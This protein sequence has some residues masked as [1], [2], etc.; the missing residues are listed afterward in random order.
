[1]VLVVELDGKIL[2]I[3]RTVPGV[4]RE[5]AIGA[6][7]Y[8]YM[9]AEHHERIRAYLAEVVE[10]RG[11]LSYQV[12]S[13]GPYGSVLL[14][15]TH[16]GPIER[17]GEVVALSFVSWEVTEEAL[18]VEDRYRVLA[19]AGIEGLIVH[20]NSVIVDAN[21]A[22]CEMF[23][24]SATDLVGQP[25]TKLFAPQSRELV[26]REAFYETGTF[27]QA[28]GQRRDGTSLAIEASGKS[29]PHPRGLSTVIA[30]RDAGARTPPRVRRIT[31]RAR[32]KGAAPKS[33]APIELSGR[34]LEVLELLAQGLT[35]REVSERIHVSART[36]DHHVS[37][38]LGKLGAPNRTAAAMAARRK[39]LLRQDKD[40]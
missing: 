32:R 2:F 34:E 37:H 33:A 18:E 38:I 24:Y 30:V 3:D 16:V 5:D 13:I 20:E 39:G 36:V 40:K 28:T 4:S 35:N 11:S 19:D 21:S 12:P 6:S 17:D 31:G 29:V 9:P 15:Q 27:H 1:L 26:S 10:T 23:G 22:A 14:Y 25:I 7:I 8:A